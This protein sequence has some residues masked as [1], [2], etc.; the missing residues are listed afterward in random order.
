MPSGP[1]QVR[2]GGGPERRRRRRRW[3][4]SPW[5][6]GSTTTPWFSAIRC[7]RRGLADPRTISRNHPLRSLCSHGSLGCHAFHGS[8]ESMIGQ[9]DPSFHSFHKMYRYPYPYP[10][11]LSAAQIRLHLT[12]LGIDMGIIVLHETVLIRAQ[13]APLECLVNLF[14]GL[15]LWMRWQAWVLQYFLSWRRCV[16]ICCMWWWRR[17]AEKLGMNLS[18]CSQGSFG[19]HAFH[20][21]T[22]SMLGQRDPSFHAFH[23]MYRYPYPYTSDSSAAQIRASPMS[24][25]YRYGYHC[26]CDSRD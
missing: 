19:C 6:V 25:W 20:G 12:L 14:L 3:P 22:E 24:P 1:N 15:H 8:T 4:P 18:D 13:K 17:Q 7:G 9:W 16:W 23:K 5:G 11:D 10:S 26:T 21:F 2:R